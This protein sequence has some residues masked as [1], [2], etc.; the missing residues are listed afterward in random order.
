MTRPDEEETRLQAGA[1]VTTPAQTQVYSRFL[2]PFEE[3]DRLMD[4]LMPRFS[5]RPYLSVNLPRV[6][7]ID[8]E[9]EIV[10]RAEIP[11]IGKDDLDITLMGD[12]LTIK[13]TTRHD[14][15]VDERGR[16][17]QREIRTSSFERSISLPVAVDAEKAV[18]RFQD[19]ILDIT[20]PKL[21]VAKHHKI[22]ID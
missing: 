9:G 15:T 10:V 7:V 22:T 14:K 11:G 19:G 1:H 17:Y 3:M 21:E 13:G 12:T 16:F 4:A 2:S 6:D 8:R 5:L 20:L 18:S